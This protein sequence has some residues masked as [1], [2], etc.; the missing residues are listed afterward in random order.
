M[1]LILLHPS[2]FLP[3]TSRVRLTDRRLTHVLEILKPEPDDI[4]TVGLEGGRIGEGRVVHCDARL[5]ELEVSLTID[6]PSK[7]SVILC[8]A[9]M[10]PI[11]L[12]RVLQTAATMGVPEIHIFHSR[13]VEKS[14]WQTTALRDAEIHRELVLGLEQAKDTVLPQVHLH[15]RFK[16]FVEDILPELLEK[17]GEGGGKRKEETADVTAMVADPS[18]D[19]F[20]SLLPLSSSLFKILILGPEGGFIPYE[21]EKLRE[22]G[23]RVVSLGERILRVETALVTMLAKFL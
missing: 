5:L 12:R 1:N 11:V 10:R 18:G 3:N 22:S 6:P 13:R 8:V 21:V 15:K 2:D 23:C 16:P 17:R 4:L 9:L 7:L 20:S 19:S 14:F